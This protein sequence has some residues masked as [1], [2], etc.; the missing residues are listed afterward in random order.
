M[1]IESHKLSLYVCFDLCLYL[2]DSI[3]GFLHFQSHWIIPTCFFSITNTEARFFLKLHTVKTP[4]LFPFEET[5]FM[6]TDSNF[7]LLKRYV[8]TLRDICHGQSPTKQALTY[9]NKLCSPRYPLEPTA[10]GRAGK[11]EKECLGRP[12]GS[13]TCCR[14]QGWHGRAEFG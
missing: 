6:G 7:I 12:N 11:M 10:D 1:T 14:L 9:I 3:M 4:L 13:L 8:Y 5:A 2:S